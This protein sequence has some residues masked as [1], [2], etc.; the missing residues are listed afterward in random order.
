M[1]KRTYLCINP[2]NFL[3]ISHNFAQFMHML[4]HVRICYTYFAQTHKMC[5]AHSKKARSKISS[6]FPAVLRL[7]P[8]YESQ[9]WRI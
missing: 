5:F 8:L 7:D 4:R 1:H 9:S 2:H 6:N 3:T